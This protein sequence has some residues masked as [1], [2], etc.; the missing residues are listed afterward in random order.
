MSNIS[1]QFVC[2]WQGASYTCVVK[3]GRVVWILSHLKYVALNP[4]EAI[5]EYINVRTKVINSVSTSVLTVQYDSSQTVFNITCFS[6]V[7]VTLWY[8]PIQGES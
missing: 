2:P 3:G 7:A 5:S 1:N 4:N 8:N 6:S